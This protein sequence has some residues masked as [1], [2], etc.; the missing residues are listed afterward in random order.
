MDDNAQ[1]FG[2]YVLEKPLAKG[3]MG[4]IYLAHFQGVAGFE[5]RCVI[6]KIRAELASDDSFVERF[7][8]EGRTLV[9]LTHSNIVQIF[10][11][12]E[13][14]GEYYLAMEYVQG[15]D[16]RQLLKSLA[17]VLM[18]PDIAVAVICEVL[19]GLSYAHRATDSAG[20]LL[21]IVHR[22]I[23]P[24]NILISEEGEVK[25]IDFGIAKAKTIE[26][27][28]GV[29]QGKFAY[30]SPEQ[31]RGEHLDSRTDLFSAGIV[32]YEMLTGVRPFEG[33]SDLQSLEK[34]KIDAVCPPSEYRRD[35]DKAID[36]IIERALAKKREDRYQSAD[37]FYDAL[38][39]YAN[40]HDYHL[41]QRD[42][43]A[44]FKPVMPKQDAAPMTMDDA[45]NALLDAQAMAF[46][47]TATQ[48]IRPREPKKEDSVSFPGGVISVSSD[49]QELIS[50]EGRISSGN[51]D[52]VSRDGRI[53][54]GNLERIDG[55][56]SSGNH[57][58]V[59][60]EVE[61]LVLEAE[62]E[63]LAVLEDAVLA[64]FDEETLR[65]RRRKRFWARVRYGAI[66]GVVMLMCMMG[67]LMIY[68]HIR[69]VDDVRKIRSTIHELREDVAN[70]ENQDAQ[71]PRIEQLSQ[72]PEMFRRG[73][74]VA[75]KTQPETATIY[76]V[77]GVYRSLEEQQK[78]VVLLPE[79]DAEIAIQ[80]PGFETCS[81]RVQ[82]GDGQGHGERHIT[83]HNCQGVSSRF[84]AS[85]QRIEVDVM[86]TPIRARA[87]IAQVGIDPIQPVVQAE[88]APLEQAG[89]GNAQIAAGAALDGLEPA[90]QAGAGNGLQA[91]PE[92][93]NRDSDSKAN[94][95]SPEGPAK[96]QP[97]AEKVPSD[98]GSESGT[99]SRADNKPK[100]GKTDKK[101][102][103]SQGDPKPS[104]AGDDE[105]QLPAEQIQASVSS[106]I[107][108]EV[109][110]N[111]EHKSLP[112]TIQGKRGNSFEVIPGTSGRQKAVAYRGTLG[113]SDVK[114]QFCEATVRI[115]DYY[116]AGDPSPYQL[117]DIFIDSRQ[118][119]HGV[120]NVLLVLPCR[121]VEIEARAQVSGTSLY[122]HRKIEPSAGKNNVFSMTP[123]AK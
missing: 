60:R 66:G 23:S 41:G 53:S 78:R 62:S 98:S 25:L 108:A 109:V 20:S 93:A 73:L 12:G 35:C 32:L 56:T 13:E 96:A 19:K 15:A 1:K 122:A 34:V 30:M 83:W 114:V 119:A 77:E 92:D 58:R 72:M 74:P 31:A 46:Q 106:N 84:S 99:E 36:G 89:S 67:G 6:K 16:L 87:A 38:T 43:A 50:N 88:P 91:A 44:F 111:G 121:S 64:Q 97:S 59:S 45:L 33:T 75:I 24:S 85:R 17:P 29:V 49:S 11:M 42:L 65:K 112:A 69:S 48:T 105:K 37:E 107:A 68:W 3:G 116:V 2:R 21:G 55:R 101:V 110:I 118:V 7:L 123:E 28:S 100:S 54:S 115:N 4:E 5:K 103:R 47:T 80:A 14:N 9:A 61:R 39:A 102:K 18:P 70:R 95:G 120:D 117:A 76:I 104:V 86:L 82:F 63:D 51:Q 22:D 94:P 52:R 40:D 90:Q 113:A 10:D 57:N 8:N 26:S 71:W 79:Q 81:F 27:C